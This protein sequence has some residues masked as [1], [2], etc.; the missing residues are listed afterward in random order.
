MRI[1]YPI[2]SIDE[3]FSDLA[4]FLA[5]LEGDYK[6]LAM[7]AL[8]VAIEALAHSM[9]EDIRLEDS[10]PIYRS[11][12]RHMK[13]NIAERLFRLKISIKPEIFPSVKIMP[14]ALEEN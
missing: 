3:E 8:D 14:S 4:H 13:S 9:E 12:S 5:G 2:E 11:H 6:Y 1:K 7:E 10:D